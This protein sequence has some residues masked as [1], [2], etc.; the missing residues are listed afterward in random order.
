MVRRRYQMLVCISGP[1]IQKRVTVGN[2]P[3]ERRPR[4]S[5]SHEQ[6]TRQCTHSGE[7]ANNCPRVVWNA[8]QQ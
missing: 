8:K 3:D 6:T 7:Q 5:I 2:E 1:V 4:T